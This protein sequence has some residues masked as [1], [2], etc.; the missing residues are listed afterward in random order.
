[1]RCRYNFWKRYDISPE[2]TNLET[3]RKSLAPKRLVAEAFFSH[4]R[5]VGPEDDH[6]ASLAIAV[7][8][9]GLTW[10]ERADINTCMSI[11]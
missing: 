9:K 1:M 6:S 5:V 2:D 11:I 4:S 3:C 7:E 8:K 10:I